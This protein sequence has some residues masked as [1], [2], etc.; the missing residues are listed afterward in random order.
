MHCIEP[1][2]KRKAV[3]GSMLCSPHGGS[4]GAGCIEF[5]PA[6]TAREHLIN[7]AIRLE[8]DTERFWADKVK[9]FVVLDHILEYVYDPEAY[10]RKHLCSRA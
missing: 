6:L 9:G 5:R 2:C 1:K 4:Y 10:E 3:S 7:C 8:R